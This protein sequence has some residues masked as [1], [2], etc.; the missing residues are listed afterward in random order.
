VRCFQGT[1]I[2]SHEEQQRGAFSL[3]LSW[4]QKQSNA[5]AIRRDDGWLNIAIALIDQRSKREIA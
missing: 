1:G 4:W 5:E 3:L 2:R